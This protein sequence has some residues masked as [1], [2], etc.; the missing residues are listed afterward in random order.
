MT[1]ASPQVPG[2]ATEPVWL[3]T[4]RLRAQRRM[5][6][7]RAVWAR[8]RYVGE[9]GL[10]ITHSEAERAVACDDE[11][12]SAERLFYA[13]DPDATALSRDLDALEREPDDR[14]WTRLVELCGLRAGESA[15]LACALAAEHVPALRR[16]FGYIQDD[17]A[18]V[19]T[20]PA[21]VA[22]L[23]G[24]PSAPR[25][26]A[27][28]ALVRWRLARPLI[29]GH[30]PESSATGWLADPRLL[31]YLL[32]RDRGRSPD[33]A[34][35]ATLVAPSDLVLFAREF[36][37]ITQFVT[38]TAPNADR[39]IEVELSAPEGTGKTVLAAQVAQALG[40]KL[41]AV[42]CQA[43]AVLDD[44]ATALVR[45]LRHAQ[46]DDALV[47]WRRADQ[48]P[49]PAWAAISGRAPITLLTSTSPLPPES[50][51]SSPR[52]VRRLTPLDRR[53]RLAL[54]AVL[55][56]ERPPVP[57]AEWRLRPAEVVACSRAATAGEEVVGT[58]CRHLLTRAPAD[59][60]TRLELHYS[61]DD[62]VVGPE[63]LGHLRE[64]AAQ[65]R[66][67]HEVLD[68]WGLSR[69]TPLGHGVTALF[70]G[71]SGTGKTMA[72]QVLAQDLG[73][74]LL[75]V[76]LAGVVNKYVGET[77]KH[78]RAVF[79]ACER[80]PVLLF[81]DEAD[82]LFGR[83]TQ[84]SDAHD[85]FANIEVDYLL[86]RME[87]FDGVAVLATNRKGDLD[88]AFMRRLRF[89][90]D[91]VSPSVQERERLW[92]A[93]LEPARDHDGRPL[94]EG[95]DYP[96]LARDLELTGA[97]IKASALAAAFLARDERAPI[98]TRHVIAAARRELQ[99]QGVVL[100][101]GRH[102]LAPPVARING[103]GA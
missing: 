22:A 69:L 36:E 75:R 38:A 86:Q 79:A 96:G 4:V 10:A 31:T 28:S 58:I 71:P 48:L 63:L 42:D 13:Q 27:G 40:Y 81:F 46:L 8:S 66:R 60:V 21:L 77:E 47:L 76:D 6:W 90:I 50:A 2:A 3:S 82:A 99:K 24:L 80:A 15:L 43:I 100:R 12:R 91:F 85:R 19:D 61:W 52:L 29:D 92:R 55:S 89:V 23:W 59:L 7:C 101:A 20:T 45:E 51:G 70:A 95:L 54:W 25:V 30:E 1:S 33:T 44:P 68:D 26:G 65:C 102:E 41:V 74:D 57:V 83:R 16:A 97:G 94:A 11:V 103:G 49:R 64:L 84:V 34:L 93:A 9:D 98:G 72:A 88:T 78:L 18:P 5:L 62:L 17:V 56:D 73:L 39:P 14:R 35:A 37:E 32:G 53:R 67:R 87:E